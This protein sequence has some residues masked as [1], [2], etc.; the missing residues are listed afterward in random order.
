[1]DQYALILLR[2]MIIDTPG[3]RELGV[4]DSDS[5][6]DQPFGK[7]VALTSLCKF[8]DCSPP[9]QARLCHS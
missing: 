3:I 6:I 1:M 9:A 8:H 5:G 2:G 4:W 7:I